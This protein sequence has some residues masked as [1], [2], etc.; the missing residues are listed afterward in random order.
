MQGSK[1]RFSPRISHETAIKPLLAFKLVTRLDSHQL[2]GFRSKTGERS[3]RRNYGFAKF[4]KRG[5]K[6]TRE[7]RTSVSLRSKFPV[8]YSLVI[9][10]RDRRKQRKRGNLNLSFTFRE[11]TG[12]AKEKR[13]RGVG[14]RTI[15]AII[16]SDTCRSP[17]II[18]H[19]WLVMGSSSICAHESW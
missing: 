5:K 7:C 8:R 4:R 14:C 1:A 19:G 15:I 16:T 10:L 12:W 6:A 9:F 11:R 13:N 3:F 17:R 18:R 2:P